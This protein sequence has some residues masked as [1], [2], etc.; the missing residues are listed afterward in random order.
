[1][2]VVVHP[3]LINLQQHTKTPARHTCT[4]CHNNTTNSA[5]VHRNTLGFATESAQQR[6]Q[7]LLRLQQHEQHSMRNMKTMST[8]TPTV[9]S[10]ITISNL[11]P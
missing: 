6:P 3:V 5:A 4:A 9:N 1:V 8:V 2:V 7:I 11:R 10:D